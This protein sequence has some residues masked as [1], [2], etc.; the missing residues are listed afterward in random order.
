MI[1][2]CIYITISHE[3]AMSTCKRLTF[4]VF[5]M[6]PATLTTPLTLILVIALYEK[7]TFLFTKITNFRLD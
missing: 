6:C 2:S 1:G 7:K 3:I 5:F 4:S